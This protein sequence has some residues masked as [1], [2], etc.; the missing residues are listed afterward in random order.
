M[1][2]QMMSLTSNLHVRTLTHCWHYPK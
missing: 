2:E 1:N